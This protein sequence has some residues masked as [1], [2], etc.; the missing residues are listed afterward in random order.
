M[1]PYGFGLKHERR[2]PPAAAR[3]AEVVHD[4]VLELEVGVLLGDLARD[5]RRPSGTS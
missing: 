5:A 1:S 4:P 2:I 3:A